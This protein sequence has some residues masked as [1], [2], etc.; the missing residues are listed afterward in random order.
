MS[1][2]KENARKILTA[3]LA[4]Q[5]GI[6]LEAADDLLDHIQELIYDLNG[7]MGGYHSIDEILTDF[8]ISSNLAWVFDS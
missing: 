8:G 5:R 2:T 4:F 1:L 7:G 6:P 3:D